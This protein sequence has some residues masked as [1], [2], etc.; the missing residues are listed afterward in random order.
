MGCT[1][2]L[3]SVKGKKGLIGSDDMLLFL[4]GLQN[5]SLSRLKTSYQLHDNIYFRIIDH[6][7]YSGG[8]DPLIQLH[9]SICLDID[10]C[11]SL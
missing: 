9:A 3:I 5:K 6:F 2:D 1:E 7:I 11:N 10:I 8:K 4:N